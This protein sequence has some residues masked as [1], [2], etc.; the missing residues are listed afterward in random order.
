[1]KKCVITSVSL[2]NLIVVSINH[3]SVLSVS[4]I[5]KGDSYIKIKIWLITEGLGSFKEN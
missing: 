2:F 1:M 4:T 3:S 5:I